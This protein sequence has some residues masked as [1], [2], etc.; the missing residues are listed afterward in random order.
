MPLA[1]VMRTHRGPSRLFFE[2]EGGDGRL[3]RVRSSERH[4][5]RISTDLARAIEGVLGSGRT[6]LARM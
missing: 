3:R 4:S 2:V 5:V 6:K 1:S